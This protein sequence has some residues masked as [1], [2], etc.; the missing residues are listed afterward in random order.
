MYERMQL[1]LKLRLYQQQ[2]EVEALLPYPSER[3]LEEIAENILANEA[4][5]KSQVP[6]NSES[7][8]PPE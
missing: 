8:D 3:E 4:E 1:L 7:V 2:P 5:R 6:P